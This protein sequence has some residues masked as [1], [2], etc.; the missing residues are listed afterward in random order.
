MH[1][2]RTGHFHKLLLHAVAALGRKD[3]GTAAANA[4]H[5]S[6]VVLKFAAEHLTIDRLLR[7]LA[8]PAPQLLGG[9]SHLLR[10]GAGVRTGSCQVLPLSVAC[11]LLT[12]P[13]LVCA[14]PG[15]PRQE[16]RCST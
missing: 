10:V 15:P 11:S 12:H 7:L 3:K 14:Q 2:E 1:N 6:Q 16:G 5:L 13:P 8:E 4:L 9:A